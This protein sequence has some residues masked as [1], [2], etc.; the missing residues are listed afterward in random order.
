MCAGGKLSFVWYRLHFTLPERLA[1]ESVA[2]STVAFETAVDDA[3]EV[4]IDGELRRCPGQRGGTM[5]AGWNAPNRVVLTRDARAGQS[6]DI[7]VFGI[8]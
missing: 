8:N 1:G 4:W 5:V 6:F 7:A 2:G 3:A